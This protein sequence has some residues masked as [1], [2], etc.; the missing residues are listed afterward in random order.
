MPR[1]II[2][3]VVGIAALCSS[4]CM[5][6]DEY[7]RQVSRAEEAEMRADFAETRVA[8]LENKL[9][10]AEARAITA[11]RWAKE[12]NGVYW[13]YATFAAIAVAGIAVVLLAHTYGKLSM[14]QTGSSS[15][16]LSLRQKAS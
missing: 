4:G 8:E 10:N 6:M 12:A 13:R 11:E 5:S 9:A 2:V 7:N 14:C 15:G 1:K 16:H 3:C